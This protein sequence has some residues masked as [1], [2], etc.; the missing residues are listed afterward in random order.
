MVPVRSANPHRRPYRTAEGHD[1]RHTSPT[2]AHH[3]ADRRRAL[4]RRRGPDSAEGGTPTERD[5]PQSGHASIRLVAVPHAADGLDAAVA[6]LAAQ[7]ADIHVDHIGAR[8]PIEFP[9]P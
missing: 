3:R 4:R 9:D 8:V 7:I 2:T 6:K 5:T 1:G